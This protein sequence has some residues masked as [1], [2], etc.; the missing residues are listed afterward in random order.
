M[1]GSYDLS[2]VALSVAVAIIAS[3]TALDMAGRVS[4]SDSTPRKSWIWL[5]AG[6]V[7]MGTGIWSMHFI[8]MLS[9]DLP[10]QVAFDLPITLLSLIIAIAASVIALFF[11]RQTQLN[12]RNLII[13]TIL[14]G[15]GIVA[16]HYTGMFAMQMSPPIRYDPLLFAASVLIA[17]VASFAALWISFQLRWKDSRLEILA[18]LGSAGVMGLAISGMHY[19]GM[20]AARF[21]PGSVCLA[22]T[23]GGI[24]S[25]TLAFAIG[26]VSFVIMSFTVIVSTLDANFG[27]RLA[28]ANTQLRESEGKF[29]SLSENA[30]DGIVM[31]DTEGKIRFW[32]PSAVRMFGYRP[33]EILGRSLHEIL[34]P[35]RYRDKANAGYSH[36]ANTGT[37]DLLNRTYEFAALRKDGSEFPIELSVSGFQIDGAWN[38]IAIVREITERKR[39]AA[40]ADYRSNLL[41]AASI[42]STQLQTALTIEDGMAKMLKTIGEAVRADRVIALENLERAGA[43]PK[44]VLLYGWHSANAPAVSSGEKAPSEFEADP[45]FAPLREGKAIIGV[46][47]AMTDGAVKTQFQRLGIASSLDVPIIIKGRYWGRICVDDCRTEREWTS[48]EVD[49]LQTLADM[50]GSAIIRDRYI[51]QLR[52]ANTIIERSPT[53]LFRLRGE[54]SLPLTY[55]SHNVTMFGYDPAEMVASPQFYK[56]IIHPDDE[57]KILELLARI[58]MEGT[59][60]ETVE[61]RMRTSD[62]IYRWVENYYTPIRDAAGRLVEIEGILTDVTEKKAAADKIIVLARTDALTGLANRAT[63]IERLQQVFAA[64][65]RGASRFAVL[66]IDLD[67]FKEVNDTLGH[68]AGDLLLISAAGHLKRNCRETDLVGRLG[69]DE[70]AILQTE[71]SSVSDATVLA[72]KIHSVLGTPYQL[73]DSKLFLSASIGISVYTDEMAGPDEMLAKADIA[74]YRAKEDGRDQYRFH[75]DDLD[76]EMRER[77]TLTGDLRR[78]LEKNEMELYYQPQVEL[79]SGRIAGMEALIRWNHPKRGLLMPA[80]FLPIMEKTDAIVAL[81]QWVLDHA[82]EQMSSWRNAGIAPMIMAVNL[83]LGQLRT[84]D[85]L[86]QFV[87]TTLAKWGLSPKD[88]ELDVTESMLAYATW[89]Y[90]DVLEQLQQLGVTIAIDDFGTQYSSLNYLKH[91]HVSRVKIPRAMIT[92]ATQQDQ[93]NAAMLRAIIGLARELNIEVMAQGVENEAQRDML[94]AA[95]STTKVQG[96]YYS[97]P[98]PAVDATELLRQRLIEPR[99]SQVSEASAAQ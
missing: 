14:M 99:L 40:A 27:K 66:Y 69:G 78:A 97:A 79:F 34:A 73:G 91:Y 82:C 10:I 81:G 95:P 35:E 55:I 89:A 47:S 9:F 24:N 83:S 93:E 63:F 90:N 42:A 8:G 1:D 77:V 18:K 58:V 56:S 11:L 36:F 29:R 37:G 46:L 57:L 23:S 28:S 16:M 13:S 43:A 94:T 26:S 65:R 87:T 68:S 2:I 48:V 3:Y 44:P 17:I 88:L 52:D 6:A 5:V 41:H 64:A 15:T 33:E 80:E 53:I 98:V 49:I 7:S 71:M 54:P 84:G 67:H 61:F 22:V 20:A 51:K 76:Q 74:L 60:S 30:L 50:I 25:T 72:S 19:T 39:L 92:A 4:A 21:A 12:I 70:F 38:A 85:E 45:W 75:S 59:Q 86:I 96:F 32:N 31:S 62:G